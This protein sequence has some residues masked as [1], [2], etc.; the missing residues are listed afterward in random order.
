MQNQRSNRMP[1]RIRM[2][3]RWTFLLVVLFGCRNAEHSRPDPMTVPRD[4]A[5]ASGDPVDPLLADALTRAAPGMGLESLQISGIQPDG[6]IERSGR[7]EVTWQRR[8]S[9]NDDVGPLKMPCVKLSWFHADGWKQDPEPM[10]PVLGPSGVSYER[11]GLPRCSIV[12]IMQRLTKG[13]PPSESDDLVLTYSPG[14][15]YMDGD[16]ESSSVGT[17]LLSVIGGP[18][19]EIL[20]TK[21]SDDTC[22][23]QGS[24]PA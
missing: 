1:G 4:A 15:R 18:N 11:L 3:M 21:H 7:L 9:D 13:L 16:K 2:V 22:G 19:L 20:K 10:C 5:P 24:G 6:T 8:R 23:Q 14:A 17:W 12:E